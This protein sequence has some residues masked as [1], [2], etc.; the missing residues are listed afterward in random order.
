Q[1]LIW[2]VTVL[3]HITT[4][5]MMDFI[6]WE[7]VRVLRPGGSVFTFEN[8]HAKKSNPEIAYRSVEAYQALLSPLG[9]VRVLGSLTAHDED[10]TAFLVTRE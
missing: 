1:D 6:L 8:T 9:D 10:H 5:S 3:Q 2:L 4:K 7:C